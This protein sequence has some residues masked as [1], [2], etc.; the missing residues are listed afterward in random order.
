MCGKIPVKVAIVE[1]IQNPMARIKKCNRK[2][3]DEWSSLGISRVLYKTEHQILD[4]K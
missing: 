3:T 4:I 2:E 1:G